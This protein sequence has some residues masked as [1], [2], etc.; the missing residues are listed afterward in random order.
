MI[1]T[2]A[3][4]SAILGGAIDVPDD[5]R[6]LA[7]AEFEARWHV[8]WMDSSYTSR[9]LDASK[10]RLEEPFRRYMLSHD[11][12]QEYLAQDNPDPRPFSWVE[13]SFP[14]VIDSTCV[15]EISARYLVTEKGGHWVPGAAHDVNL[16]D[17]R[18]CGS[19]LRCRSEF[20]SGQFV[21]VNFWTCIFSDSVLEDRSGG[22]VGFYRGGR[23][24][25]V[26]SVFDDWRQKLA[27]H[28]RES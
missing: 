8:S 16:S 13:Y 27:R 22:L 3:I 26:D 10:A 23:I 19:L 11:R 9:G 25:P 6:K 17:R 20:E 14:V 12:L 1:A 5:A 24:V 4:V 18:G 28:S 7:R 15:G 21:A 2:F